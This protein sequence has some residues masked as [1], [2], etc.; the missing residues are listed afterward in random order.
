[1]LFYAPDSSCLQPDNQTIPQPDMV[2]AGFCF[3][4]AYF[5]RNNRI[6]PVYHFQLTEAVVEVVCSC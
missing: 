5:A 4:G 2:L 3:R 1:M 6:N